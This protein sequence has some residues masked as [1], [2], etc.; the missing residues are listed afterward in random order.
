KEEVEIIVAGYA[1]TPVIRDIIR[2]VGVRSGAA[3]PQPANAP[4]AQRQGDEPKMGS[5]T[6]SS[7]ASSPANTAPPPVEA[8]PEDVIVKV[9]FATNKRVSDKLARVKGLLA[10]KVPQG[11]LSD[12]LEE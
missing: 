1:K 11:A 3:E 6:P 10:R 4:Q 8:K 5:F 9:S 2:P 12:V 7:A